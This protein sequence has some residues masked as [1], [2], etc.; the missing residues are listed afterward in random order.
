VLGQLWSAR[1]RPDEACVEYLRAQLSAT[2][3]NARANLGAGDACARAGRFADALAS[4]RGILRGPIGAGGFAGT[5]VE[6]HEIA[7]RAFDALGSRDSARVHYA[8]VAEAWRAADPALR[9]RAEQA[10]QARTASVSV[11]GPR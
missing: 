1:G 9:R 5:L 3:G 6:A 4:A 11:A 10:S 7:A 2:A 8:R